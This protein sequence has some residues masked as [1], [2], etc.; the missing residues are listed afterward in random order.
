MVHILAIMPVFPQTLNGHDSC[1][2]V[3]S[4]DV[5]GG[6]FSTEMHSCLIPKKEKF[7]YKILD[8]QVWHQEITPSLVLTMSFMCTVPF[9]ICSKQCICN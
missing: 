3:K 9:H 1:L 7:L 8:I 2:S 5:N 4:G 6:F